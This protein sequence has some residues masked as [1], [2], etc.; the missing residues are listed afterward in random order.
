MGY[1]DYAGLQYLWGKL[2]EKFAPK[3]HSH[4]DRYY[5]ESE[6][7]G[8]LNS[9]VNNNEAGAN[10]LFS[11][12]TTSWTATPTDDTYFIRQDTGGGNQFGR[13]KFST[14]WNYIKGKADGTYQPKGNYAASNHTHNSIK[15]A[16]D[17]GTLTLAYSK[18]GLDYGSYSWLAG[19]NGKELRAVNK[20]QFATADHTHNTSSISDGNVNYAGYAGPIESAHIDVLRANRLAFLPASGVKVE[21][22]V[23]SG[24]TWIDYGATDTQKASLFAMRMG[25]DVAFY[26]GKH[27]KADECTTKDQLRITVTPVDRYASVNMLYLWVSVAGTSATVNISRS[28]IGAKET[29]TDVRTDVPI[30]GWSGPNEIRFSG[31]TFGGSSTQ[32]GNAYAY[33]FTFKNKADGKGS[34]SVMDIRMYGP[35]A[36]S[37]PNSM[38]EKDH[39]YSWDVN[40]NVHFPAQVTATKFNGSSTG[41]IDYG[42]S[43]GST[44]KVGFNGAGLTKDNLTHIA[45]YAKDG[46]QTVI[47]DVSRGVLQSWLNLNEMINTQLT[48]GSSTPSDNDFYISQYAGGGATATTYHRR[49]VSA[50]WSYIKSKADA[51]YSAKSHTHTKSQ[52]TDFPVSLKNPTALTIQ[53][54][55]TTAAT[56]DGSA[57][58]TVNIT[59]GNIGLGNVDNTADAN[60]S[61]KYAANAGSANTATKATTADSATTATTSKSLQLLSSDRPTSMNF[62]LSSADY[63]QKVTYAIASANTKEGKPPR[64]SLVTTYAWDNSGWGAQLAIDSDS[65]PR[66]YVRGATNNNGA[67]KWDANWKTVAFTDDKPATAGTADKANSVDWSNVQNKPSS[68]PPASHTH[69]YLPT[70]GG[71]MSGALNFANGIWNHVGDDVQIGDNNTS[72]SFYV[73]GLN[74]PTN[75]KLK[76]KGDT[77]TGSGDSATITYDGGNLVI[78]KTIQANLSGNAST[79]TKAVSADKATSA[80]SADKAAKLTTARTVSGGSDITLSFNYDGSGNSTANIGFYSCK[81]SIGNTNNYPFHRFAKLDANKNAWVDNSMTFLISQDYSGGGYGICRLVY[82]SNADSS[83]ASL[84]AE[85]LVRKGLSVDTVQVAIKTDK[86]NGAYCDAFYKSSGGYTSVVIRAIASGG[87]ASLGR[88]WT[89]INSNETDGTTATDKK[90]SSECWKTIADAGNELH[91]Q[92][93][94]SSASA[95]DGGYVASAG[96]ANSAS[97]CTGNS[98]SA[99]KLTSSAGSATQPIYFKDGKPVAGTYTLGDASSKMVRTLG[100]QGNTGWTN[101]TTDDKYVPTMSFMAYWN[102]AYGGTSSNL[103]YCDRGRFGTIVT[104]GS[105]DYAAAGHTHDDRYYTESEVNTKLANYQPKGNYAAASHTHNYAGSGSAGGSA[106]SAIKLDSSAGSATQPVYFKDGKPVA[107]TYAL[108]KTVPADA[109]FTDTNTWRGIQNNLTSDSTDQSLSAAQGKALKTLVDGKAPASHKHTKSQ[110]TDFPTSMPASDVSAWAKAATKPSYTKAEVG[111][112]NVNNTADKDKSVKYAASAGSASQ[113]NGFTIQASTSDLTAGSSKLSNNVIYIVYE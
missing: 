101:K 104:K 59:K 82:R 65:N 53:T 89:L 29:F 60:K 34:I 24:A 74:G 110:I 94:S 9:K 22:S 8:K 19:W 90:T 30:S 108:N 56:Y 105:G 41:V 20:N 62:N 21:Y 51:V 102:G 27:T 95:V 77:S 10:G 28:T 79:A 69:A 84:A 112:S 35:S 15:D 40:Q 17:G 18:S 55:G 99:T 16:G 98:A 70:G 92:A 12:L 64:D 32:T 75:I 107:T 86:T 52:I 48:T 103:Q 83:S 7:D 111:L 113:L 38:M 49:P 37:V 71:T 31:G 93:Y 4:D 44:I 26:T 96:S 39:I 100:A 80:S 97:T 109:K 68:Y 13:V 5:T 25:H 63:N 11:K 42:N 106:N 85:W 61:V 73:Q 87:R 58:K 45:G 43:S 2:K 3:S 67:S 81:H 6:M 46:N 72:G 57:A 91:K 76:K 33:R 66:M 1:L 88:T 47:K 14:L 36:W 23:D 78:D 50:L 54:N